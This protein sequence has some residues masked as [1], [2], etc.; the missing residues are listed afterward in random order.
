LHLAQTCVVLALWVALVSSELT[1]I[2]AHVRVVCEF[3]KLMGDVHEGDE[4]GEGGEGD[5]AGEGGEGGEGDEGGEGG[6]GDERPVGDDSTDT[7]GTGGED[8]GRQ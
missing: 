5:E 2:K 3:H 1:D 4:A 8:G 6:E 7:N